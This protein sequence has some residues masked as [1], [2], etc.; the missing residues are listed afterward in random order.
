MAWTGNMDLWAE[1]E[2]W[3]YLLAGERSVSEDWVMGHVGKGM[4]V[5]D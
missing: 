2:A 3:V 5:R 4:G 1:A